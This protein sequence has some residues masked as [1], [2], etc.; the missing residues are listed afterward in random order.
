MVDEI[1]KK[2]GE[3]KDQLEDTAEAVVDALTGSDE[4]VDE[5]SAPTAKESA[6][7]SPELAA[8]TVGDSGTASIDSASVELITETE[9]SLET[10]SVADVSEDASFDPPIAVAPEPATVE[11]APAAPAD[12]SE[13]ADEAALAAATDALVV[14]AVGAIAPEATG[15]TQTPVPDADAAPETTPEP[16]APAEPAP[17][18]IVATQLTWGF[19]D[20]EGKI[21][22]A[23]TE[24][25]RGRAIGVAVGEDPPQ[26]PEFEANFLPLVKDVEALEVEVAAAKN[27]VAVMGRV[28]R[29]KSTAGKAQALGDFEDLFSRLNALEA[30]IQTEINERRAVKEELIVKSEALKDST[31]WKATGDAYKALFEEWKAV[32]ATGREADDALWARFI[33]A[34]EEFNKARGVHFEER[35]EQWDQNRLLKQDLIVKA[36]ELSSSTEWRDT[37][38][39]MRA[40]FDD[41]KKVGSAGRQSDEELWKQFRAAQEIFYD[42]RKTFWEENRKAKEALC[43]RSEA[44][45]T[46]DEERE[47]TVEAMKELMAEWKTI[48]TT[49][50]RDVD[51]ALWTRFRASQNEFFD[52]RK[53]VTAAR[54]S[55]FRES[56]QEK[57]SLVVAIE[58]LA[59]SPDPVDAADEAKRL[60]AEF[61]ALPPIRQDREEALARRARKALGD[62]RVNA[63]AEGARRAVSWEGKLREALLRSEGQIISLERAVEEQVETLK[64]LQSERSSATGDEQTALD[65]QISDLEATISK[66]KSEIE[67]L[68]E[69]TAEVGKS[70]DD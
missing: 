33:G 53:K 34:R 13:S 4:Q 39:A 7:A 17:E 45:S 65:T 64:E 9:E 54:D 18:P 11:D 41:W 50:K 28:R 55:A 44:A 60:K 69:S 14:A 40:V 23:T 56:M 63:A 16:A 57:E 67:R 47:V 8:E 51:D 59:Y 3:V 27:K 70:L 1:A 2:L 48:G 61:D 12:T 35:R 31:S 20:T 58:A 26:V 30:T 49:G 68:Q 6:D 24:H 46:S 21:Y 25:F 19:I 29:M 42:R 36:L 66:N 10:A 62:I 32:G 38:I 15:S 22:Q 52:S 37:S 5:V 43:E